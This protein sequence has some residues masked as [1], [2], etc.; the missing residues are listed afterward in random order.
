VL[1]QGTIS[2]ACRDREYSA[3]I[4]IL[5]KIKLLTGIKQDLS[6]RIDLRRR[7]TGQ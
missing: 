6:M 4:V 1:R 3:R 2:Q 7:R 5:W